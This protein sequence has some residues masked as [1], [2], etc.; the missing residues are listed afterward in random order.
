MPIP[1]TQ[2]MK[3]WAENYVSLWNAGDK[4]GWEENWR[5]LAPGEFRMLDPD[6][7]EASFGR[8]V[9]AFAQQVGALLG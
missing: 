1:T 4:A 7:F 6:G 5:S 3:Q 9:A 2:Q 8:F